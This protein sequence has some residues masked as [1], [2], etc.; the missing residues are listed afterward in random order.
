MSWLVD[1][2][3][4][5]TDA[6]LEVS[7]EVF[8]TVV[9][10]YMQGMPVEARP[11]LLGYNSGILCVV[12]AMLLLVAFNIRQYPK[13]FSVML[14]DLWSLRERNHLFDTRTVNETRAFVVCIV[15]MCVCE[16][17]LT[18][19]AI[20]MHIAVPPSSL[21]MVA[22]IFAG[23]AGGYY[24]WQLMAYNFIGYVFSDKFSTSLWLRGFNAS[25]AMLGALLLVP[26]LAVLFY[27][28][29]TKWLLIASVSLYFCVRLAFIY[30]GFRIFYQN[31]ASLLYFILY[32]CSVEIIPL[33]LLFNGT[34][35]LCCN[36]IS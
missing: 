6:P 17:L 20:T 11:E 9:T 28:S 26:A 12:M 32:L 5:V 36:L 1:S 13:F 8:S 35:S 14:H 7:R 2:L 30:K 18:V 24:L 31:F 4:H 15:L 10:P 3:S 19:A 16:A 21:I 27:P 22:G 23:V 25:Q 29:A 33:I 34:F